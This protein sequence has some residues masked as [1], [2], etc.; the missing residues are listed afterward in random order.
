MGYDAVLFW[1]S[2][3]VGIRKAGIKYIR[4][5]NFFHSI[6]NLKILQE[7]FLCSVSA[8]VIEFLKLKKEGVLLTFCRF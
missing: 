1:S 6:I 4:A 3:Y 7:C 2:L 5:I 8:P